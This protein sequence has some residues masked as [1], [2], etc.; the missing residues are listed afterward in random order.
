V[1]SLPGFGAGRGTR[2]QISCSPGSAAAKSGQSKVE[3]TP[4]LFLLEREGC[5][6]GRAVLFVCVLARQFTIRQVSAHHLRTDTHTMTHADAGSHGR[7]L[8]PTA[9]ERQS[10]CIWTPKIKNSAD[11]HRF[12][13][14]SAQLICHTKCTATLFSRPCTRLN[15]SVCMVYTMYVQEHRPVCLLRRVFFSQLRDKNTLE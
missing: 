3:H 15:L 10:G 14:A 5:S 6:D 4:L 7:T 1:A 2:P 9:E 11:N 12:S 8:T 13:R